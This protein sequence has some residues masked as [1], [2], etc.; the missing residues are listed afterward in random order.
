MS[1]EKVIKEDEDEVKIMKH[2]LYALVIFTVTASAQAKYS[3]G[4]GELDTPYQI[5]NT[6]DLMMLANDTNDYNKC[7]IMTADIDL[8]P[9]LPGN[10]IFATAVIANDGQMPFAGVFDGGNKTIWNLVIDTNGTSGNYLGLFGTTNSDCKVRNLYLEN[11]IIHTGNESD[12]LGLLTGRNDGNISNCSA[13]GGIIAEGDWTSHIGGLAGGNYGGNISMCRTEVSVSGFYYVGGLI[14]VNSSGT[15]F[16][17]SSKGETFGADYAGGLAANNT[18]TIAECLATGNVFGL[19]NGTGGLV[20][21]GDGLI[22][23]CY[24]T[25][26]VSGNWSVGGLVGCD[27]TIANCYSRGTVSG[28]GNVGGLIG[29]CSS[30]VSGSYFLNAAGPDNGYGTPLTD[31]QMK[32][33]VSFVGWD[34][35]AN[36]AICENMNYP[37]LQWSIPAA[38]FVC[39]DGVDFVDY[40]FF[41]ERWLNTNCAASNNCDGTDFDTSGT[42][43]IADLK[44]FCGYWMEGM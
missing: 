14:G 10:R 41:A 12:F 18:G 39:P 23:N 37:R 27:A 1:Y 43:D 22:L 9:N 13:T 38:D 35:D 20:G 29:C 17:C 25:G 2:A 11:A 34:F 33:R 16:R 3:G 26:E 36:W 31:S 24:A 7:F 32:Q 8:D 6:D 42:V 28:L 21:S 4:T 44:V 40:S 19:Y 30:S 5:A 15:I